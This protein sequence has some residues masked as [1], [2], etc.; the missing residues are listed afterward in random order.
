MTWLTS[1][2]SGFNRAGQGGVSNRPDHAA[3][4]Q[5]R[6]MGS[7]G[8]RRAPDSCDVGTLCYGGHRHAALSFVQDNHSEMLHE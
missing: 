3:G 8:S 5:H 6:R 4:H 7:D 1:A 2:E